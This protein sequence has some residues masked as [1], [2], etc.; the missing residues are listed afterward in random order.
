MWTLG[1]CGPPPNS[2]TGEGRESCFFKGKGAEEVFRDGCTQ[3]AVSVV[4]FLFSDFRK[5]IV[6]MLCLCGAFE[7]RGKSELLSRVRRARNL[8]DFL[9]LKLLESPYRH[10]QETLCVRYRTR[11]NAIMRPACCLISLLLNRGE[12][13]RSHDQHIGVRML[14]KLTIC[15]L[16]ACM[17]VDYSRFV[18]RRQREGK[19]PWVM[20]AGDMVDLVSAAS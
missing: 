2:R 5:V 4:S 20:G 10:V 7:A 6:C 12:N 8:T 11:N 18:A 9:G 17:S 19:A 15:M 3:I 16:L 1:V 13:G 14:R